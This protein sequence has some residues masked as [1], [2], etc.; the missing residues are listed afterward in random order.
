[1]HPDPVMGFRRCRHGSCHHIASVWLHQSGILIW[2]MNRVCCCSVRG[3]CNKAVFNGAWI[4]TVTSSL[5]WFG[6]WVACGVWSKTKWQVYMAW[7]CA[8]FHCFSRSRY[9]EPMGWCFRP[10]CMEYVGMAMVFFWIGW[11]WIQPCSYTQAKTC[12]PGF[13]FELARACFVMPLW[14]KIFL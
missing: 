4:W 14:F 7:T 11:I 3:S 8:T 6:S 5:A 2:R 9:L 13:G 10:I 1:M 12:I